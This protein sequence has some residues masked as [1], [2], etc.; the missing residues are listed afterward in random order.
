[1]IG[2]PSYDPGCAA[3]ARGTESGYSMVEVMAAIMILT[4]AILPMVGMFA[5]ALRAAV[6]GGKYDKARTLAD[7]KLEEIRALPYIKPGGVADSV[8]QGQRPC[9]G[10]ATQ[11][12]L[13]NRMQ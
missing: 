1:M 3:D 13:R 2:G 5:A 12:A 9:P 10:L 8:D 4:L 7:E 6:L 11:V